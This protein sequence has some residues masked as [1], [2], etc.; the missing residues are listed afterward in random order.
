MKFS[1]KQAEVAA[2][3][4]AKLDKLKY[5][6]ILITVWN[7]VLQQHAKQMSDWEQLVLER[8]LYLLTSNS[9]NVQKIGKLMGMEL[10]S[11]S[12]VL[13]YLSFP[14]HL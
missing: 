6:T 9:R 4:E 11:A 13:R 12:T 1:R 5:Q 7:L 2:E 8:E 14:I 3:Y 10:H